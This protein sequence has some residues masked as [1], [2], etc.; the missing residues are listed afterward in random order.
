MKESENILIQLVAKAISD[1]YCL[2]LDVFKNA[3]WLEVMEIASVQGVWAVAFDAIE[4]LPQDKRPDKSIIMKWFGKVVYMENCYENHK[5]TIL[6]LADFY[7]ENGFKMM[8][9][10]GYGLS[11]CWPKP[12]HRPI[13]DIDIYLGSEGAEPIFGQKKVWEK[14]DKVIYEKLNIEVDNTHHHHSVFFYNGISVEN[15]FD[16]INSYDHKSSRAFEAYLKKI[17]VEGYKQHEMSKNLYLPSD[18]F[19]ALFVLKHCS[20]HFASTEINL[21]QML[22]WLLLIKQ[23]HD[24]LDWNRLYEAFDEFGL[25]RLA[26]IFGSIGVKYFGMSEKF[27]LELEKN[28]KLVERVLNDILSPEFSECENGT[29]MS[30]LWIKPRRFWHNR[31]KHKLCYS[32]SFISGF[33]WTTYAKILKPRHFKV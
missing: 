18:D 31:W 7:S 16:F 17:V 1:N 10:K 25:R 5:T 21:R 13:G 24:S 22:D 9:L 3:N 32:D 33:I 30:G 6:K 2:N 23:H 27:F 14:A 12:E 29:L 11:K 4:L 19:N 15:H 20:G 26:A 28:E 8:L